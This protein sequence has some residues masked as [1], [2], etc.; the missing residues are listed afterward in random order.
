MGEQADWVVEQALNTNHIYTHTPQLDTRSIL[1]RFG[2]TAIKET[3]KKLYAQGM[4]SDPKF[5]A[6]TIDIMNKTDELTY[7]QKN[8]LVT[9][10]M[11]A[12]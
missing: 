3:A 11:Y 1:H 6:M 5:Q 9:F 4:R 7:K 8:V 2:D 10:I 12:N